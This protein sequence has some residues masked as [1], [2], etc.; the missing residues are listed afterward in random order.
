MHNHGYMF[1]SMNIDT[2]SDRLK[3]AME[4][5]GF[6]QASLA[7]A[8]GIAQPSVW[9]ITSGKTQT[10]SKIVELAT[11]LGVRPEWL[12]KGVGPMRDGKQSSRDG[13]DVDPA[14][15]LPGVFVVPFWED[16][17]KT[18]NVAIVPDSVKSDHC[19]AYRLRHDSGYP[20]A[21]ESS[22]IVIDTQEQPGNNDFVYAAVGNS[23]SVYRFMP[24]GD[25]GYLISSN[26]RLPIIPV[27]DNAS[28][29]G[30][31]VYISRTL[32]R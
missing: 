15:K 4:E 14:T 28:I 18:N 26:E 12:A 10:S 17:I 22:V 8:A 11:A 13:V 16:N 1:E 5:G 9:K 7:E 23:H 21:P 32:K 24:G 31:V 29:V 3:L 25:A 20:E 2:L 27:G 19:R 6:T 30:V